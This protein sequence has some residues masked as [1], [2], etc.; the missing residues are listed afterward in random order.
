MSGFQRKAHST[1]IS[2]SNASIRRE[3]AAVRAKRSKRLQKLRGELHERSFAHCYE[4]GAMAAALL[5]RIRE[6]ADASVG[7]MRLRSTWDCWCEN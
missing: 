5:A 4:T 7:C 2:N 3:Q 1:Y 6:R